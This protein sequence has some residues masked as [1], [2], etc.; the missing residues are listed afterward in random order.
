[1]PQEERLG[2]GQQTGRLLGACGEAALQ[3]SRP[4]CPAWRVAESLP[5]FDLLLFPLEPLA[6]AGDVT[7][8]GLGVAGRWSA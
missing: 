1:M 6:V 3:S 8:A 2:S 7:G 5:L 4:A